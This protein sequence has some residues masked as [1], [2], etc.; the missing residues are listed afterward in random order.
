MLLQLD[1]NSPALELF[2]SHRVNFRVAQDLTRFVMFDQVV[3]VLADC[4]RHIKA[5][6]ILKT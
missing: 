6:K 3:K 1:G 4:H 5:N 2:R